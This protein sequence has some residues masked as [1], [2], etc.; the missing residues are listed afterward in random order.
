MRDKI[1][2]GVIKTLYVSSQFQIVDI[3]TK[4]LG[5]PAFSRLITCLGLIDIYSPKLQTTDDQVTKLMV[6]DLRGSV[7]TFAKKE[8][9]AVKK[10]EDLKECTKDKTEQNDTAET[11][12][13]KVKLK[14]KR[15]RCT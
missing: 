14:A 7:E 8:E 13:K 9:G 10:K 2:E 1:T 3:F 15:C 5:L 4:A 6:H 12:R 11:K